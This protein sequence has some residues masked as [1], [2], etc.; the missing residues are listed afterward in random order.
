MSTDTRITHPLHV[1]YLVTGLVFL[2]IS[3]SWA[4]RSAGLVDTRQLGWLL[5]LMLVVAGGVGL[6]ASA[7]RGMRGGLRDGRDREP[8]EDGYDGEPDPADGL[9]AWP[10]HFT[11][12]SG[13]GGS[14]STSTTVLDDLD[15]LSGLDDPDRPPR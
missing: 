3:G 14:G 1:G 13:Q 5:P 10:G 12:G 2:G 4:L 15:D 11:A 9:D 7:A 8:V 6:V